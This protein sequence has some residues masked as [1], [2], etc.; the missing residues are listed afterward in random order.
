[1]LHLT[2][3]MSDERFV[4]Q[5]QYSQ[6]HLECHLQYKYLFITNKPSLIIDIALLMGYCTAVR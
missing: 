1:M 3:Y 5:H 6:P 2:V 4:M